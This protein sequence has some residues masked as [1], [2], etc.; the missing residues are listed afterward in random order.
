MRNLLKT[1]LKRIVKDKLFFV[2]CI[3]SGA[4]A[5]FGP[6]L[7]KALFSSLDMG[8]E[9][10]MIIDAKT[11]FFM[12]FAP[13]D[14]CGL[15]VPILLAIVLCK[16]FTQGTIRNK[17]IAGKSRTKIFLSLFISCA[18]TLFAVILAYAILTLAFSLLFFEYQATTFRFSDFLY[19]L[20]SILL[21]CFVYLFIAAL[22][23]FLCVFM[24]NMG[25]TIVVYVAISFLFALIGGAL[26]MS[27]SLI[28]PA[29]KVA[30]TIV[31]LLAKANVFTG[32]VI[33]QGTKY[34]FKDLLYVLV[35]TILGSALFIYLGILVFNKKDLK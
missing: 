8:E 13:G 28:D 27:L 25:L 16:D 5:I 7:Y 6:L 19:I 1:D 23:A 10:G 30:Y 22:V 21:E 3:L 31:E 34:I 4:F 2:V 26:S 12:A 24:K 18:I 20:E 11:L 15:I 32:S 14:N 29:N 17:I 35:P 9:L 33:G